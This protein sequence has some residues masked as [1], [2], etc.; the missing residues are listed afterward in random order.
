MPRLEDWEEIGNALLKPFPNS[1][2]GFLPK[3]GR[4]FAH[5]DARAVMRRLDQT[6]GPEGWYFDYDP[7]IT[8][9]QKVIVKGRLTINGI[10]KADA[11]EADGSGE[12]LKEAVSD[13]IKR[14]AV[15][16]GVGRFLYELGTV[17]TPQIPPEKLAD[18]GIAA[19]WVGDRAALVA[20]LRA[21]VK[22]TRGPVPAPEHRGSEDRPPQDYDR[23]TPRPQAPHQE[24]GEASDMTCVADGCGKSL[25]KGQMAVSLKG[26]GK[27]LCPFHQRTA[28]RS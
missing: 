7:V 4:Q 20:E 2:I 14:A 5:I 26:W 1:E 23:P 21:D 18:A 22:P 10:T 27:A 9:P 17:S 11:G 3:A 6:V 13:S 25:T 19:G 8:E 16:W 12:L 15:L 28:A 24:T